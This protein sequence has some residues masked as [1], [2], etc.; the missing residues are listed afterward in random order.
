MEGF[1]PASSEGFAKVTE[2]NGISMHAAFWP[3]SKR[4]H[5]LRRRA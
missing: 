3:V 4:W 5:L 1:A 2:A